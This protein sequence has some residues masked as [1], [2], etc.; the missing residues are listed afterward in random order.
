MRL[1]ANAHDCARGLREEGEGHEVPEG[2]RLQGRQRVPAQECRGIGRA[3]MEACLECARQMGYVQAELEVVADNASAIGLY[4]SLGATYWLS[5]LGRPAGRRS[6]SCGWSFRGVGESS[7]GVTGCL[8]A[9]PCTEVPFVRV[10]SIPACRSPLR[11]SPFRGLAEYLEFANWAFVIDG[12]P[13]TPKG[14]K[15][16][17]HEGGFCTNF[18]KTLARRGL[19]RRA[20]PLPTGFEGGRGVESAA[21]PTRCPEGP[22]GSPRSACGRG[23]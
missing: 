12:R 17:S 21:N 15:T 3:L 4:R 20:M 1:A 18:W 8:R 13:K 6:C 5:A 11:V 9:F 10:I 2:R 7:G 14:A 16:G 23:R 22:R 19:L